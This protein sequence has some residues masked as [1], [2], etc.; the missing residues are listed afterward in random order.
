MTKTVTF[1]LFVKVVIIILTLT[2]CQQAHFR[3]LTY[4]LIIVM[5]LI[6]LFYT[7][8]DTNSSKVKMS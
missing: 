4:Q 6:S 3:L 2:H 1:L 5:I 7:I 8:V